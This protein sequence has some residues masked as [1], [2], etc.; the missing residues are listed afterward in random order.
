MRISFN[1]HDRERRRC[2]GRRRSRASTGRVRTFRDTPVNVHYSRRR[3]RPSDLLARAVDAV[4][5]Q[6]VDGLLHQV[7][8]P[9]AEHAEAQVLQ[10]LCFSGGSIQSPRGADA[11]IRSEGQKAQDSH[12]RQSVLRQYYLRA[13]R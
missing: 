12:G 13:A 1:I 7:G 6:Q 2:A 5:S 8:A 11:V 9:A 3:P 4:G 10:E